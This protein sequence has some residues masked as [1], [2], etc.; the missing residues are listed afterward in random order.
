MGSPDCL[1][2]QAAF[3]FYSNH[4]RRRPPSTRCG[5]VKDSP[6]PG[7]WAFRQRTFRNA[8]IGT[9]LANGDNLVLEPF[10]WRRVAFVCGYPEPVRSNGKG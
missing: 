1:S 8:Q 7:I 9:G 10:K 3:R 6:D 5:K 4:P 2:R